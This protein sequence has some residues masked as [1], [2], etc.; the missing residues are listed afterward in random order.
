[1]RFFVLL[2]ISIFFFSVSCKSSDSD[3][4]SVSKSDS[5]QNSVV[6]DYS[7]G[8]DLSESDE[9]S[10]SDSSDAE[11]EP[12]ALEKVAVDYNTNC[13]VYGNSKEVVVIDPGSKIDLISEAVGDRSVKYVILTHGHFDHILALDDIVEKYPDAKV[14][15]HENDVDFLYDY[16]L[17]LSFHYI[18]EKYEFGGDVDI[19]L[20]DENAFLDFAGRR[21]EVFN[22]PGHTD[23]SCAFYFR[24][25]KILFP[26]DTLMNMKIG[27][28]DYIPGADEEKLKNSIR[29]KLF[30]L[31]DDVEIHPGHGAKSTI[32]YEKENNPAFQ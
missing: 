1:M 19:R 9:D 23:G 11:N 28:A 8:K 2:L 10:I 21:I 31:P 29:E 5:D 6:V 4:S 12:L 26:G 17:N 7:N 13:Y 30:I 25:E 18:K 3:R 27:Y 15:V 16:E 32:G 22:I 24:D 20:S 14:V